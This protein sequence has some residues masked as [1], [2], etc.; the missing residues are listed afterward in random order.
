MHVEEKNNPITVLNRI[1]LVESAC[2]L[3]FIN[4]M[5]HIVFYSIVLP[6]MLIT[7]GYSLF[8]AA[9]VVNVNVHFADLN[10]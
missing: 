4:L 7:V 9:V 5:N 6:V 3:I 2:I 1:S 8:I 10:N